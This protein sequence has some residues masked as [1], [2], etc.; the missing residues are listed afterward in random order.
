M[1]RTLRVTLLTILLSL[2]VLTISLLGYSG[3][4]NTHATAQQLSAKIIEQ[5]STAIDHRIDD[6][7]YTAT[8]QCNLSRHLLEHGLLAANDFPRL[9][10]T[11][12]RYSTPIPASATST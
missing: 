7:I 12:R 6:L 5:T 11:G 3:Y 2:T 8:R 4:A 1:K 10:A 9:R